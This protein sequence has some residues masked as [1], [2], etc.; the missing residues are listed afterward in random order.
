[1]PESAEITEGDFQ[2][3]LEIW[4]SSWANPDHGPTY[5]GRRDKDALYTEPSEGADRE[6]DAYEK[7]I[8]TCVQLLLQSQKAG[9]AQ[10]VL[11]VQVKKSLAIALPGHGN[12]NYRE[13]FMDHVLL[14]VLAGSSASSGLVEGGATSVR[15]DAHEKLNS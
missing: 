9:V 11:R 14:D 8:A 2:A 5:G 7:A 13:E 4:V 15:H 3:A 1:M 6:R 10:N 12:A